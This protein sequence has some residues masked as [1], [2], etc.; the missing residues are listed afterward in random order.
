[1]KYYI[2]SIIVLS[3]ITSFAFCQQ[4]LYYN[5]EGKI[6][7][8][9]FANHHRIGR[10]D[11][12]KGHFIGKV[13]DFSIDNSLILTINYDSMGVKNGPM[14][15]ISQQ[16]DTV[17]A[18]FENDILIEDAFVPDSVLNSIL[19]KEEFTKATYIR[20]ND[21]EE[22]K[23][24]LID[25]YIAKNDT[26]VI[27]GKKEV[28]TIVEDPPTFPGGMS[29]FGNILSYF[30]TYPVKA[31]EMGVTGKVYVQFIVNPD[32]TISDVQAVKGI[33]AG[34]DEAAVYA[35]SKMPDWKPGYQRG[36]PVTVRMIIPITFQ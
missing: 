18:A 24:L 36:K 19:L 20:K 4:T 9:E 11:I 5:P 17:K 23:P 33:G 10:V 21:Y 32:G 31:Q 8:P 6:T 25:N 34:C 15:F 12:K 26:I 35:I 13:K 7:L 16:G 14:I 27:K 1:M 30:L 3:T 22:I 28:F 29:Q 2:I